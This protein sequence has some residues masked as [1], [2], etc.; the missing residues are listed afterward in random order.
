MQ[1]RNLLR[2]I[3][4]TGLLAFGATTAT[5]DST[6]GPD[7]ADA[8]YVAIRDEGGG[9]TV[10]ESAGVEGDQCDP[11]YVEYCCECQCMCCK[12]ADTC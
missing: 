9:L 6:D 11:C 2:T 4:S 12:C 8:P 7:A 5:A 1:R 10:E 3:G